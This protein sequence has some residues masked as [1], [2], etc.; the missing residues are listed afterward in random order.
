MLC[1]SL[2][3]NISIWFKLLK[4][5]PLLFLAEIHSTEHILAV[6]FWSKIFTWTKCLTYSPLC[7][8]SPTLIGAV[9]LLGNRLCLTI[10][11]WMEVFRIDSLPLSAKYQAVLDCF[12]RCFTRSVP[13]RFRPH[14]RMQIKWSR[15]LEICFQMTPSSPFKS[16]FHYTLRLQLFSGIK[17]TLPLYAFQVAYP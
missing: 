7:L 1:S 6:C 13:F 17:S 12:C 10:H 8:C 5:C 14:L 11:R 4:Q 15:L 2:H 3:L 16:I 9:W